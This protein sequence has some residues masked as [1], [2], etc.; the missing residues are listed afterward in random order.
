MRRPPI[1]GPAIEEI[2]NPLE[3][4]DTAV[5]KISN[6][7]MLGRNAARDGMMNARAE[8]YANRQA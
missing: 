2:S 6:G 3:F 8:P 1:A 5:L 4:Q 7:M